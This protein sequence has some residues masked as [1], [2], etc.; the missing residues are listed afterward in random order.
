MEFKNSKAE[1]K[2]TDDYVKQLLIQNACAD[3]MTKVFN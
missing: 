1:S 3:L 2:I